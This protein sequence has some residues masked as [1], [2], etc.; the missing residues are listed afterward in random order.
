MLDS[1][2]GASVCSPNAIDTLTEVTKSYRCARPIIAL[3]SWCKDPTDRTL[4][5][6]IADS[7]TA[8]TTCTWTCYLQL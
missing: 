8:S 3:S 2:A 1:G 5:H 6:T 4:L 7:S